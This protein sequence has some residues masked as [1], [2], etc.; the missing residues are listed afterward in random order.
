MDVRRCYI[1]HL[2]PRQS[3]RF[4]LASLLA[5]G[6]GLA[7]DA[8][9]IALAPHLDQELEVN[10]EECRVLGRIC[11][12][13]FVALDALR[14]EC[15]DCVDRLLACGLLVARDAGTA[16]ARGD[17]A[18][19]QMHWWPLAATFHR[20]ARWRGVD[21]VQALVAHGLHNAGGL[22]A[23]FGAPPS[24]VG[25]TGQ[26]DGFVQLP[27]PVPGALDTLLSRRATCRNFDESRPLPLALLGSMAMRTFG[28]Q[29]AVTVGEATFLKKY[30]AS[31][32]GLHP[33][34]AWIIVRRVEGLASGLYHYHPTRHALAQRRAIALETLDPLVLE[35]LAGQTWFAGAHALV[36]MVPRFERTFW[37]YR[38]HAKAYRAVTLDVGHLSQ[39]LYLSA[40]DL[41]LGA[42]VTAAINDASL[43]DMLGLDGITAAPL[44]VCGFGWRAADMQTTEFDPAHAVWSADP[45]TG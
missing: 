8:R 22:V 40:T 33:T 44:A 45:T 21:G 13:Q 14:L 24:E 6:N 17:A 11:R 42:F 23:A 5:G 26:D 34:D 37:K 2:E 35:A 15:G 27:R 36:V 18:L 7:F 39:T 32:G 31:A 19:R 41:G 9:W 25:G 38:G 4:D 12:E 10:D 29:A 1:V 20:A 43:E 28:A 3:A 16:A 30:T